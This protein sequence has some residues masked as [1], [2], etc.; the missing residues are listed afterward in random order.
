MA[1][2]RVEVMVK[3]RP[4]TGPWEPGP[5]LRDRLRGSRQH[6]R[7]T[8]YAVDAPH[9]E[10]LPQVVLPAHSLREIALDLGVELG[11]GRHWVLVRPVPAQGRSSTLW[12]RYQRSGGATL[13]VSN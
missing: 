5:T 13:T 7:A 6:G 9:G 12:V 8:V 10:P 3:P 11:E 4:S 1:L 2:L